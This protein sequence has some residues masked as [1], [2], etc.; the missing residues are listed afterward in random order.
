MRPVWTGGIRFGLVFI[1]VKLYTGAS[2]HN[3]DLDMVRKG[4]ACP[5]KYTRVCKNDG[6]EVPWADIV[7]G[8]KEDDYYIL[9]EDED[10]DKIYQER[11]D[12]IDITDF[13]KIDQISP[14]YFEKPYLIEPGKGAATTYNLLREAILKSKMGGL[15][16][17]V[18]RNREHLALLMADEEVI[19]LI[20][21]RFDADM[22]RPKDLKLP[23]R[24]N[25][26]KKELE[27]AMKLIDQMKTDF[28]PKKYKDSYQQ[29]LKKIIKAKAEHKEYKPAAAKHE[30]T[31]VKD[32]M[33]QLKESL[34]LNS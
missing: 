8:Y 10:F 7:K 23:A 13:V 9:L 29:K 20:Q 28:D 25:P 33:S 3:I 6:K 14:R 5:I 12:S 11:S 16:K 19:F 1:P 18:M 30:T 32:L 26:A 31:A 22:R 27:M 17:F 24:K 4:D 34:K 21:M 2:T 15:A